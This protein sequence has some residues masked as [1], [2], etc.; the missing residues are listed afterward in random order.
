MTYFN[1]LGQGR[2]GWRSPGGGVTPSTLWNSIYGVWN[3]DGTNNISVKNAWNANGDAVDSKSGVNGTIATP[4]G[5][6]WVPS[7]MT[8]GSGKLGSGAFTFNGSNFISL[9]NNSLNLAGDFTMSLWVY[10]PSTSGVD[11]ISTFDNSTGPS[12]YNGW[13]ISCQSN[14]VNFYVYNAFGGYSNRYYGVSVPIPGINQWI[15]ITVTKVVGQEANIYVNGVLGVKTITTNGGATSAMNPAYITRAYIGASYFFS[16]S[17]NAYTVAPN[18]LK[19]DAIQVWDGTALE[20]AAVTELYNSGNGQEYP[21]TLSNQLIGTTNDA[22]PNTKNGTRPASTLT[23][24]VPGPSF[25][26]GKIGQAFNFDGINDIVSLANNSLDLTGDFSIS[27]WTNWGRNNTSQILMSNFTINPNTRGWFIEH[28]AGQLRFR[29][30]NSTGGNAF[31]IQYGYTPPLNTWVH[32][33]FVHKNN[34][35]QM[36]INGVQVLGDTSSSTHVAYESTNWPMIG[37]NRYNP[38]T[39]QEFFLGK[40]DAVSVWNRALTAADVTELYNA[41]TGKQYPN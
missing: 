22:T 31:Y 29:G 15:H 28:A 24:G 8:Y 40:L 19:L 7:T 10:L 11:L 26:A 41:G 3:A 27:M 4:S 13:N 37:A 6:S 30:F 34:D 17:P 14:T 5:T 39:Y 35:N 23:G 36:Y 9:P 38:T 1:N 12:S 25:I 16:R 33:T 21:F 20:Q 32:Y 18:G 2:V